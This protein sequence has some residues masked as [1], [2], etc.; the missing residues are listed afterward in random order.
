MPNIN[1][2]SMVKSDQIHKMLLSSENFQVLESDDDKIS[3][4][5]GIAS[6]PLVVNA[7]F[8]VILPNAMVGCLSSINDKT[9]SC[10]MLLQHDDRLILNTEWNLLK[11][12]EFGS[13]EIN[14]EINWD[15]ANKSLESFGL[16]SNEIKK[17]LLEKL[18]LV[19][20]T[21]NNKI[22]GFSIGFTCGENDYTE[23]TIEDLKNKYKNYEY[24][25]TGN[26]NDNDKICVIKRLT[27]HEI[28][29]VFDP[30][31]NTT[32][33]GAL[34]NQNNDDDFFTIFLK[35]NLNKD[36]D[37]ILLANNKT[38]DNNTEFQ[39]LN[40]EEV[41]NTKTYTDSIHVL[42]KEIERIV[43]SAISKTQLRKL[44]EHLILMAKNQKCDNTTIDTPKPEAKENI[45]EEIKL[46]SNI[47]MTEENLSSIV[48]NTL[49]KI[50]NTQHL[51]ES[52][53]SNVVY[54]S[55]EK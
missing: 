27:L 37:N 8:S 19:K 7:N 18:K 42:H 23:V 17:M 55:N 51:I 30:A 36:T 14:G 4:I 38:E 52:V 54:K 6:T 41:L 15:I 40:I 34:S 20:S 21:N 26:F 33:I 47:T 39:V 24:K 22:L 12:N 50:T 49:C 29:L 32:T 2:K 3:K 35:S 11:L 48:N 1:L 25:N 46:K 45:E 53:V 43:P 16:Y 5:Y 44:L 28:S 31:D 13:L 9:S 10:K